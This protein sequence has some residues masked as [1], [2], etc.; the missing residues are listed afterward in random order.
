MDCDVIV[1]GGGQNGLGVAAYCAKAGLDVVV[2]ERAE[3]V[4]GFLSTEEVTLPGFRHSLHAITLG[5][6]IPFY[7]HFDL[8]AFGV[9]FAKP[10]VEY[11]MLLPDRHLIIR[12][13]NPPANYAAIANFSARDA[14]TIEDLYRQ[15]HATW[16]EEFFSPPVQGERG[17][18]L[19]DS[20]RRE[21]NRLCSLSLREAV[22]DCFESDAVRLLFCLRAMEFTGDPALGSTSKESR[23]TGDILFRLVCDEEYQIAVGGTNELAQGIARM[24]KKW[25]GKVLT[26]SPVAKVLVESGAATGV[27]LADGTT[28]RARTVVSNVGFSTAMLDL[29][30][31]RY[32]TPEFVQAVKNLCSPISGTFNLHLAVSEPPIYRAPEARESLCVFLGY[33]ALAD[34]DTKWTEIEQGRFP[35]KPAFHCGCTTLHDPSCAPPGSHTLYL[36]QTI[37]GEMSRLMT[38][39]EAGEW[40]EVILQRWR[41]DCSNLTDE[42]ILARYIYY[43]T[44]WKTTQTNS[45]G[46]T[47]SHG[48]YYDRR[49]LP[50]FSDYRTPIQGLYH[51]SASSHP[52]GGVR[53]GPAHNASKIIFD[54]LGIAPWWSQELTPGMPL[55]ARPR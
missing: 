55:V 19:L 51:A 24:V 49:P 54:D 42:R 34:L 44:K 53:F 50:G 27:Q 6:Y 31:E 13:S 28:I 9:E 41:E 18:A 32:L 33:K 46:V 15:F 3:K 43:L 14:Q 52:G 48:Q 16:L 47:Y 39:E 40:A 29:V 5:S 11:A 25:G 1:I 37:P 35:T 17:R 4:G 23:G 36:W 38:E 7:Q 30:G 12:R 21:Y 45:G 10:P 26:R 20:E 2:L 8:K 22:E